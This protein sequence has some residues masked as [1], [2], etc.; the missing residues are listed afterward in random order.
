MAKKQSQF[1]MQ[2]LKNIFDDCGL[3]VQ[4]YEQVGGGDINNAY[5]LF[6]SHE[7]YFLKVNDSD[8]YPAMFVKEAR[9]IDLLR[10]NSSLIIPK[11]IKYGVSNN[12]QYLLLEWLEKGSP[13]KTM[14][15][16]FGSALAIMHKQPQNFFGLDEDNYI[17]SL[18]QNNSS[19]NEWYSFYAE[20]RIMPL[21]KILFDS[22][23]YSSTDI[24]KANS[25]CKNLKDFF[26]TE[27]PSVLHGDLWAG[28]F[29]ITSSGN[30]AIYDP[31]VYFGHREMDIGMTN[32][33][34]GFDQRFYKAYN[35]TYPLEK[36]WEKRIELTQLY[37]LLVH[38]V[39]FG[40][41]YVMQTKHVISQF[42]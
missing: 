11:V 20:C 40:G 9:G 23:N 36:G 37:P 17:G 13:S 6:T 25:F 38:A 35:E 14:W 41:H 26:P 7:K 39:L 34:G 21:V 28:N 10:K 8:K 22:E 30:A 16:D 24:N 33:F 1:T 29:L 32:L 3:P 5:C 2:I 19:H 15:E 31:A 4:R 12:Y 18:K 27:L 42:E